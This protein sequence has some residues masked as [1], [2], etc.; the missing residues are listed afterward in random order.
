MALMF[1]YGKK[2]K[3]NDDNIDAIIELAE[4]FMI[5]NLKSF[6]V[7]W[8]S[9]MTVSGENCMRLLELSCMYGF[10][11]PKCTEY[12]DG[13]LVE[14]LN[15]ESALNITCE[16]VNYILNE[17]KFSYLPMEERLLF[18]VRWYKAQPEYRLFWVKKFLKMIAFDEIPSPLVNEL[19]ED[20]VFGKL[21]SGI[22][23]EPYCPDKII[24]VFIYNQ[25]G[26]LLCFDPG[27]NQWFK[28]DK[29]Y[30]E[31]GLTYARNITDY[32]PNS[33]VVYH[34]EIDYRNCKV[35][36]F[37]LDTNERKEYKVVS[38]S[39]AACGKISHFCNSTFVVGRVERVKTKRLETYSNDVVERLRLASSLGP[40]RESHI[41]KLIH[42]KTGK[43]RNI[44]T[45]DIGYC[46]GE[47]EIKM[48]PTFSLNKTTISLLAVNTFSTVALIPEE[49]DRIL[50]YDAVSC[51]LSKIDAKTTHEDK[52]FPAGRGFVIHNN[53]RCISI[54][55]LSSPALSQ[56]YE[57]KTITLCSKDIA[58]KRY[59]F[60]NGTW[61][62]FF[63]ETYDSDYQFQYV[64]HNTLSEAV[65]TDCLDWKDLSL[66]TE[67]SK[68][69]LS[70]LGDTMHVIGLP[71]R[72]LRCHPECPH[73]DAKTNASSVGRHTTYYRSDDSDDDYYDSDIDEYVYSY[74][75]D[76]DDYYC[77][78]D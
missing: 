78:Y 25:W 67:A 75:W 1:I 70:T 8:V 44:S 71:R 22:S 39:K 68:Y 62:R 43:I 27:R 74:G 56:Q 6:C 21:L 30:N 63:R 66:P 54:T 36:A 11:L 73:C 64:K 17:K 29:P 14:I 10:D 12:L 76:D 50:I 24:P 2:P 3:L 5:P 13:H 23:A 33:P 49:R 51:S 28:V 55:R 40:V 48:I 65:S 58:Q 53:Q 46:S 42:C 38:D 9:T 4:F 32:N 41:Q 47:D 72:M 20:I 61:F 59:Y 16:S 35:F 15:Q 52:I 26:K 18:V 19:K 37:N 45:V 69:S 7:R 31:G 60:C 34:M 77:D 57:L